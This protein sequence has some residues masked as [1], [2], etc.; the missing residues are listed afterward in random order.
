MVLT[1][2]EEYLISVIRQLP[3]EQVGKVF[4]WAHELRE[5]SPDGAI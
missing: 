5:L 4:Q 1:P 2:Q 3:P